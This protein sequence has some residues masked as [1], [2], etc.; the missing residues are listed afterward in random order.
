LTLLVAGGTNAPVLVHKQTLNASLDAQWLMFLACE[1]EI[2]LS[3]FST[4][5]FSAIADT[6]REKEVTGEQLSRVD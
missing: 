5:F 4:W 2:V 6:R 1:V 3:F